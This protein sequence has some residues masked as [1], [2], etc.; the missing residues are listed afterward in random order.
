MI[1][2]AD[3]SVLVSELLRKRGRDLLSHP[4]IQILVAEHQWRET[5]RELPRRLDSIVSHGHL[6]AEQ[7]NELLKAANELVSC[8]VI[9][10]VPEAVYA[11]NEQVA[12]RR[13]PRDDKDWP[14]VALAITFDSGILAADNDF[15]GCGCPTWT[16]ETLRD[17]LDS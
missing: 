17:E 15:F 12:R 7:A 13:I 2:I 5:E 16:F 10:I 11:D 8:G 6:S 3:A 1:V 9:E 4:D 14:T